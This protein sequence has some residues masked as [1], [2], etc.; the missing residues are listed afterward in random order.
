MVEDRLDG[1]M[2]VRNNGSYFKY[3]EIDPSLI[4]K[5]DAAKKIRNRP[6]RIHIPPENHPWRRFTITTYPQPNNYQQKEPILTK[7]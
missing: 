5:A 7:S 6:R 4:R 1:S 3:S 2:H